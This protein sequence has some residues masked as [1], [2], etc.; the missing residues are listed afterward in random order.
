MAGLHISFKMNTLR[1]FKSPFAGLLIIGTEMKC[2]LVRGEVLRTL[3]TLQLQ[4][5]FS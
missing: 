3:T 5:A 1:D 4:A 2:G